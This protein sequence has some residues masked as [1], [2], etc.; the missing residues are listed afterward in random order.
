LLV[1]LGVGELS[2]VPGAIPAIKDTLRRR[3]LAECRELARRALEAEDAAAV[4]GILEE[5]A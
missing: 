2:A 4:R 5:K 1:G 3:R